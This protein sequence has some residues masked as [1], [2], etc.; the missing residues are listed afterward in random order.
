M[1]KIL[2]TG[3]FI[4]LSNLLLAQGGFRIGAKGGI[5]NTWLY[6]KNTADT[7]KY[8]FSFAG[9]GGLSLGYDAVYYNYGISLDILFK[10]YNQ[11][12]H[13]EKNTDQNE[14]I[15]VQYLSL[16]FLFRLRPRGQKGGSFT[17]GGGYFEI[18]LAPEMLMSATNAYSNADTTGKIIKGT[19]DLKSSSEGFGLAAIVGFGFHQ[20][21][22]ENWSITHGI[23]L[24]YGILSAGDL[25]ANG[26]P[27]SAFSAGYLLSVIYKFDKA[28]GGRRR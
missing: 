16:P 14:Q 5:N 8:D 27:S 3:V 25:F 22:T 4:C 1:R 26:T 6:N 10:Q 18:G 15:K 19:I 13:N 24:S 2:V 7:F 23:R 28:G 17:Y 9:M 20:I 11:K 21:G 12:I